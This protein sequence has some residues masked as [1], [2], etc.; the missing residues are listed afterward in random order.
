M[1]KIRIDDQELEVA[2][3]TSIIQAA[4]AAKIPIP[5]F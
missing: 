1:L 5:R 3:G 2:E 4:D